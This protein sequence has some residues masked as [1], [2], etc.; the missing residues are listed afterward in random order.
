M[1]LGVNE[2]APRRGFEDVELVADRW[3]MRLSVTLESIRGLQAGPQRTRRCW[4]HS[5]VDEDPTVVVLV[6]EEPRRP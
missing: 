2:D 5:I 6:L 3:R 4:S 1:W